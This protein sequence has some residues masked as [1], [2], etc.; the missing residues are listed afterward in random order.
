[1]R[2]ITLAWLLLCITP[3][4]GQLGAGVSTL[5]GGG[6]SCS[7]SGSSDGTGPSALFDEPVGAA[8]SASSLYIVDYGNSLI[9]QLNVTTG[10]S[11][12]VAGLAGVGFVDGPPSSAKFYN[13]TGVATDSLATVLYI[14][15]Y[16]NNVIRKLPALGNVTTVAGGGAAGGRS[17]GFA[18]G[19]GV[20][21]T[22]SG[23]YALSLSGN[24]LYIA[25][26]NNNAIRLMET[27]TFVV[28]NIAGNGTAGY[29]DGDGTSAMFFYPTGVAVDPSSGNILVADGSNNLIRQIVVSNG[30]FFTVSTLAGAAPPFAGG[31]A[32][33]VGSNA[34]FH[35]PSG[36]SAPSAGVYLLTESTNDAVR[37]VLANG[38]VSTIAGGGAPGCADGSGTAALFSN[39]VAVA[40]GGP[41]FYVVDSDNNKV[42]IIGPPFSASPTP[43]WTPS[44]SATPSNSPTANATVAAAGA[45][46]GALSPGGA[47]AVAVVVLALLGGAGFAFYRFGGGREWLARAARPTAPTMIANKNING[48]PPPPAPP[49]A[50]ARAR[51]AVNGFLGRLLPQHVPMVVRPAAA[52]A[53]AGAV[54][55]ANPLAGGSSA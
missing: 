32:D 11:S 30:I 40:G 31:F 24:F 47:A 13:P 6:S 36:L 52:A 18:P 45:G 16:K 35:G 37:Q 25:D 33:G 50:A 48:A 15:D 28:Q 54:A 12:T 27:T 55:V 53:S 43:S 4:T 44:G 42:R 2:R 39:P 17:A 29:Q 34:L 22:F 19:T 26:L 23:P 10:V 1:M 21:A 9:R 8:L 5:A 14:A 46:G 38:S 51:A 41:L 3:S 49:T 7:S 20:A